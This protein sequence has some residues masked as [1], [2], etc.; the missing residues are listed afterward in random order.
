MLPLAALLA[1]L[2]AVLVLTPPGAP[3]ARAQS[4]A[5]RQFRGRRP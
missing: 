3:E 5:V 1:A 4:G 2:S